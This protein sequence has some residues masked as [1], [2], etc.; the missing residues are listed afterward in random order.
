MKHNYDV[1]PITST[2]NVSNNFQTFNG[3]TK[4]KVSVNTHGVSATDRIV[5]TG[6][7]TFN[8]VSVNG[9]KAVTSVS[10]VNHFYVSANSTANADGSDVGGTKRHNG[11]FV[12]K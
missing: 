5:F 7:D 6:I 3:D 8:N 4:V 11:F 9:T 10:G 12:K 1:T 2:T